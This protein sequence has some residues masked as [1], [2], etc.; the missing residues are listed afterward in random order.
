MDLVVA[1][2][3]IKF[4][5]GLSTTQFIQEVINDSNGEFVFDCE[6]VEFAKIMTHSL[7]TVFLEY[8][9]HKGRIRAGTR[10]N[11]IRF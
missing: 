8:H 3:W 11:N 10:T 2:T 7:S 4:G 6:F 9:D 1:K 5:E